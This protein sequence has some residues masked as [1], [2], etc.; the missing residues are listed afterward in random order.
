MPE[1]LPSLIVG[2]GNPGP[3]Y[4]QTRHNVGWLLLDRLLA[5]FL[6]PVVPDPEHVADSWLWQGR[7]ARRE[8]HLLKPL[9]YMNLS[10]RAVGRVARQ[11]GLNPAEVL[12][13]YDDM[14][15][16]LGRLR[17]R[18][19]GSSGGHNGLESVIAEFGTADVPRL[20][21]GIGRQG[22][23][24]AIDHVLSPFGPEERPVLEEAL[25][26]AHEA[27]RLALRRGLTAAM[28]EYNAKS[29]E[30]QQDAGETGAEEQKST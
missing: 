27:V 26:L 9:T 2:L 17:I 30:T 4:A 11:R 8:L 24:G 21:L 23:G 10:G 19:R 15:L 29:A 20:R 18:L 14:D 5:D 12:V 25:G 28:N 3:E 1:V 6:G 22:Q 16:P 13:L 7:W